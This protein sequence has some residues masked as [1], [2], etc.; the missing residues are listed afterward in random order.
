MSVGTDPYINHG[1][2]LYFRNTTEDEWTQIPKTV[3]FGLPDS[4][5]GSSEY[6]NDD[7]PDYHK[8][9]QP[10]LYEPGTVE[11][12]YIYSDDGF[13][14]LE[15]LYQRATETANRQSDAETPAT[16]L[17]KIE[18]PSGSTS[19]FSG[20]VTKNT[21]P[22]DGQEDTSTCEFAIQVNGPATYTAV[23]DS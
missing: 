3:D 13:A 4:E 5:L 12:T 22:M 17:W 2:K 20:Y 1:K 16:V 11:G 19:N 6:T 18:L 23:V 10:G 15:E 7:S 8:Q 14:L 21:L 9:Y